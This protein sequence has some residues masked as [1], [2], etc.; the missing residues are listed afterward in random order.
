MS[1]FCKY[2]KKKKQVSYDNGLTWQDVIPAE[3][4]KGDLYEPLSID[5]G[6][7]P[8]ERWVSNGT[9]CYEFDKYYLLRKQISI[10]NGK[11]WVDTTETKL[12]D[13]IEEKSDSCV[14]L[15]A[16]FLDGSIEYLACDNDYVLTA[17]DTTSFE[18][19]IS[20]MTN[21]VV[22]KCVHEIGDFA[23]DVNHLI[24]CSDSSLVYVSLGNA[25]IIGENA[26]YGNDKLQTIVGWN[27]IR[28]VGENAF[29][30]CINLENENIPTNITAINDQVFFSNYKLRNATIPSGITSIGDGAFANCSGLTSVNIP[31]TVTSIGAYAFAGCKMLPS[32]TI[33]NGVGRIQAQTFL[34]CISLETISI[35][36]SVTEIGINALSGC[37]NLES[38]MCY[39]LN[40]PTLGLSALSNTNYC[41]I[42]VP[43]ESL[44][45][46]KTEWSEYEDRI[47]PMTD[48]CS[49]KLHLE[50]ANGSEV[51]Y[52]CD[53][54]SAI[55][56][57]D[58]NYSADID[59]SIFH[60]TSAIIGDC[61]T[62]IGDRTFSMQ[63]MAADSRL[64]HVSFMS[65][66]VTTIGERAF[67]YCHRLTELCK[68]V[69]NYCDHAEENFTSIGDMAFYGCSGLTFMN[70]SGVTSLSNGVFGDCYNLRTVRLNENLTS[71][72]D[73]AFFRCHSLCNINTDSGVTTFR[74]P[75]TVT[76]IGD[77]AFYECYNT[78]FYSVNI[79]SGVTSIGEY[80]FNGC[81]G[82]NAV[83]VYPTTPPL[84]GSDA[85]KNMKSNCA[86]YVPCDSYASYLSADGW[87]EYSSRIVPMQP[88]DYKKWEAT[89]SNSATTSVNCSSIGDISVN[90]IRDNASYPLVSVTIGECVSGLGYSAF[91]GYNNLASVYQGNNITNI[92]EDAFY[93][94]FRLTGITIPSGVTS[95]GEDAFYNCYFV[96]GNFINNSSLDEV[97]N[98]YW[99]ATIVDSDTDGFIVKQN[100][101]I[102]YR[103]YD[104]DIEIPS[105]ITSIGRDVFYGDTS[106]VR[107]T[108]PDTVTSIGEN[109]F[110]GCSNLLSIIVESTTPPALGSSALLTTNNCP[111]YVPSGSVETYKTASGWSS[112]ASRIAAIPPYTDIAKFRATYSDSTSYSAACDA[113]TKLTTATTKAHST[114]YTA[115]TIAII[116]DCITA[117]G[118]GAFNGCSSLTSVTIPDSVTTISG[119]SFIGCSGLTS[120]TIPNNVTSIG[121]GAFYKCSGLTE[122]TIPSGVTNIGNSAFGNCSSLNSV[123][124]EATA[125]PRL[126]IQ[127]FYGSDGNPLNIIIYV[128]AA[129]VETYKTAYR[130]SDYA[131][132]IQAI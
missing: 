93:S 85:F 60:I 105:G 7:S 69:Y 103:G 118:L 119:D 106:I 120:V 3:Y 37:Y 68:Y 82:M 74:M 40:P 65:D 56:S 70:I 99:G 44:E 121:S 2:Y 5:C 45:D 92:G 24:H 83:Y 87:S 109:A 22:G 26:F 39:P 71:I 59:K 108:I 88:C 102:K 30:G 9:I 11:T 112:Y 17:E 23:F 67:M 8:L 47:V 96:T 50:Y 90:E 130:W 46:Y 53:S 125:P 75:D 16:T 61:V 14:K 115:M 58:T 57:A 28:S 101:L 51:E 76:T 42:Y 34:D 107:V 43:C 104:D 62:T 128:P 63:G 126:G 4:Q 38:I 97:A 98:N 32:V 100:T 78:E 79:P 6:Y 33:P 55:T 89:Y 117:I 111:I 80:A 77:Y 1:G 123:T 29:N 129:S 132:L 21:A 49:F 19:S 15:K 124:V 113:N 12:S 27:Q 54:T 116:G 64:S 127:A 66:S 131:N 18:H 20:S 86:I 36:P 41:H 81:Y 122:V 35:P 91:A 13:I 10:D 110:Y 73:R 72:G 52:D 94:C 114:S 84:L 25:N 95:I 48:S 31:D